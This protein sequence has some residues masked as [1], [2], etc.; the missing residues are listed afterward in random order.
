MKK[1][2]TLFNFFKT[3]KVSQDKFI[4]RHQ[5]VFLIKR[6]LGENV[7]DMEIQIATNRDIVERNEILA[8]LE[9]LE[10]DIHSEYFDNQFSVLKASEK[11][12][13]IIEKGY[14]TCVLP[15]DIDLE[16]RCLKILDD[17]HEYIKKFGK[18]NS[19]LAEEKIAEIDKL[20]DMM[21]AK[22]FLYWLT[23]DHLLDTADEQHAWII[24]SSLVNMGKPIGG[25]N[26]SDL[27][28][29]MLSTL[30]LKDAD[31]ISESLR[32]MKK[33][34]LEN[35]KINKIEAKKIDELIE[36]GLVNNKKI[37]VQHKMLEC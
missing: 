23:L 17:T 7:S 11:I 36:K 2:L 20:L 18:K 16:N 32:R 27:V 37:H 19:S 34:L 15:N 10:G 28:A 21:I 6:I 8:S 1:Y 3:K 9:N 26:K 31:E 33:R 35:K 30:S 24:I 25:F 5:W 22:G 13:E 14:K 4:G 12:T 29:S